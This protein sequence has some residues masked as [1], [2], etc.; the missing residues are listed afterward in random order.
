VGGTEQ[1]RIALLERVLGTDDAR[2]L[3]GIGDDAAV[4]ALSAP[5]VCSVD[6][7]VEGVHF[8]RAWLSLHDLGYKATMAALSDLAAM[9]ARPR[10]VLSSLILPPSLCD[11]ELEQLAVG[12]REAAAACGTTVVGGN[13]AR[14]DVLSINTTVLGE[15]ERPLTRSGARPGDRV[16]VAGHLGQAALGLAALREG[17]VDAAGVAQHAAAIEAWRRPLA[18]IEDGLRASSVAHAA[19]DVSDGLG[20]DAWRL[21]RASGVCLVLD[22]SLEPCLEGGEDYA[23]LITAAVDVDGFR[24]IGVVEAA[25]QP[26]DAG[27]WFEAP[28]ERIAVRG[29]D[30]F[31]P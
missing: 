5:L 6:A 17:A 4:I 28:R 14:G 13:L 18:R 19:I 8:E 10:G 26:D 22:R 21:A 2:V 27:L 16:L 25:A 7:C 9:G 12:Q 11:D 3:L 30:H 1:E 29:W 15:A 23:L 24:E 31:T 20:L